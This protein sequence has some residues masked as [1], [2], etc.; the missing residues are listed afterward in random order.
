M[1]AEESASHKMRAW[2][3]FKRPVTTG[4]LC[5][6]KLVLRRR[7]DRVPTLITAEEVKVE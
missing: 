1:N 5:I 6:F 7:Y 3:L 4:P 2:D